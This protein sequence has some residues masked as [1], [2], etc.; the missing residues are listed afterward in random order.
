MTRICIYLFLEPYKHI[1]IA[2]CML[3]VLA[4]KTQN[5]IL[6]R[7]ALANITCVSPF[8]LKGKVYTW[9]C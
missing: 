7:A 5:F 1:R 2:V 8:G 3:K 9:I 6:I 4:M